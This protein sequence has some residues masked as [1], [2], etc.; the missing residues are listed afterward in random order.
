[1][2]TGDFF[3]L[4][5]IVIIPFVPLAWNYFILYTLNWDQR[6]NLFSDSWII[7]ITWFVSSLIAAVVILILDA[8]FH[9]AF[10]LVNPVSFFL[11]LVAANI[12]SIIAVLKSRE[13][14]KLSIADDLNRL[15]IGSELNKELSLGI[16]NRKIL[17]TSVIVT[18]LNLAMIISL[19][20]FVKD[21]RTRL[22]TSKPTP[23]Y[24]IYD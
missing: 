3:W 9:D 13:K 1:M 22:K 7:F 21:I 17:Q 24:G 8:R 2:E 4:L 16:S 10:Y 20:M 14:K 18:L 5:S 11:L 6:K 12:F 23:A 19:V 15:S